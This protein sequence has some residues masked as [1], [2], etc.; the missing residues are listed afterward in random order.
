LWSYSGLNSSLDDNVT[1]VRSELRGVTREL[2]MTILDLL[3]GRGVEDLMVLRCFLRLSLF[4]PGSLR[5]E[6]ETPCNAGLEVVFKLLAPF[7]ERYPSISWADLLQMASV[8][9]IEVAGGPKITIRYGRIDVSSAAM[10]QPSGP[11]PTATGPWKCLPEDHL[12]EV[13]SVTCCRCLISIPVRYFIAWG[14]RTRRSLCL[15]E[16]ILLGGLIPKEAAS[17]NL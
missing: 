2:M 3:T 7:K 8:S 13:R 17:E 9:A 11:L 5:F 1:G 15:A 12:R 16:L 10:C 4:L 14:S 6:L